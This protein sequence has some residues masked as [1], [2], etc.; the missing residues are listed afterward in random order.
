MSATIAEDIFRSL[1]D[2]IISGRIAPGQR[3]EEQVVANEFG[4]SRTPVR[5]ALRQLAATGLVEIK[6]NRGVTVV[7]PP[8]HQLNDMFEALG[9]LE[10]L[11]ARLSAQRMSDIERKK[12]DMIMQECRTAMRGKNRKKYADA[13]EKFHK[14]IYQGSHNQTLEEI[15][16]AL[17]QRLEPFRRSSFFEVRGRMQASLKEH[18]GISKAILAKNAELAHTMMRDHVTNSNMNAVEHLTSQK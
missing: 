10:A 9:E 1:A 7:D 3:M 17:W 4:V 8:I 12:L 14:L 5:D 11:C 2:Q 15:A 6:P 18:E 13:N 16:V